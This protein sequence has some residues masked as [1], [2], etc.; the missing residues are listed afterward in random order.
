M[1]VFAKA[2]IEQRFTRNDVRG[3]F[4]RIANG[5]A[6]GVRAMGVFRKAV[7]ARQS[8]LPTAMQA[9]GSVVSKFA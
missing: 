1:A 2:G 6:S 7:M 9:A 5:A 3:S 8:S 4:A